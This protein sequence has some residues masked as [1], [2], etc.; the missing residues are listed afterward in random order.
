MV[1][2]SSFQGLFGYKSKCRQADTFG[3]EVNETDIV[4]GVNDFIEA[5]RKEGVLVTVF[6]F[7]VLHT[8]IYEIYI[9]VCMILTQMLCISFRQSD[10][11]G[12]TSLK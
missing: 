4:S 3:K 5:L 2:R 12:N 9:R 7:D 10:G 8:S 1:G 11:E 6:S